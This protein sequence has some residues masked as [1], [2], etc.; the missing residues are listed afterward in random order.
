MADL[1]YQVSHLPADA[2]RAILSI[3]GND[4]LEHI[5]I[6]EQRATRSAE[7]LARLADMAEAFGR[8]Y[9][10]VLATLRPHVGRLVVCTI[11]EPPLTAPATARLV[12]VPLTLLNDQIIRES[13]RLRLDL[14]DLR[15]VCT[16]AS[17]FVREIEPSPAGARKIASAIEAVVREEGPVPPI[18]LFAG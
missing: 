9:R 3:G 7:V 8:R 1:R 14:L 12:R 17:D 13:S 10:Q 16:A 15:T 6:L 4:A 2:D 11:Y 5:G 18:R